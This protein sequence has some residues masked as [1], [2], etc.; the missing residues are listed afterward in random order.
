MI[1]YRYNGDAT[2]LLSM[3]VSFQIHFWFAF[4]TIPALYTNLPDFYSEFI[5][6]RLPPC[7]V[8][9]AVQNWGGG[10]GVEYHRWRRSVLGFTCKINL[11]HDLMCQPKMQCQENPRFLFRVVLDIWYL[12]IIHEYDLTT[13]IL[14][15]PFTHPRMCEMGLSIFS[16]MSLLKFASTTRVSLP[17][18]PLTERINRE[19][20][21]VDRGSAYCTYSYWFSPTD[22]GSPPLDH[23]FR[24]QSHR[25]Q[26]WRQLWLQPVNTIIPR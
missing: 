22:T 1:F 7:F 8:M 19:N 13:V 5:L 15:Q 10:G 25:C 24:N 3:L 16:A 9:C 11:S 2:V 26:V 14:I 21:S 12:Q 6:C 23:I 4:R 17:K 18:M 20:I